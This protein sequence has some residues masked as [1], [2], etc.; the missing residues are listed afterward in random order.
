M[1]LVQ[2]VLKESVRVSA[3]GVVL[4]VVASLIASRFVLGF[5]YEAD[6]ANPWHFTVIIAAILA[7]IC[8]SALL[9]AW[10]T[11]NSSAIKNIM[12]Q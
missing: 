10:R 11:A 8:L 1:T 3:I 9:P 12:E 7:T 4:G 5:V 2:L 6:A